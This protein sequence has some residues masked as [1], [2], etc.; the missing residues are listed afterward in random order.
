MKNREN[1]PKSDAP[2]WVNEVLASID[3]ME[4]AKSNPF[5]FTRILA[6]V[7]KKVGAW[8]KAASLLSKPAFAF[9]TVFVFVAINATVLFINQAEAQEEV[10]KMVNKEQMLASEFSN[11]QTYTLVDI[12][13]DK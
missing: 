12:N 7:E 2:Q 6:R 11:S 8:E 13:E 10:A 3:G 1:S 4:R 5:L 9:A